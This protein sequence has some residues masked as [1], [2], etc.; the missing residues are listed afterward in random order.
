MNNFDLFEFIR[1]LRDIQKVLSLSEYLITVQT[2]FRYT[3]GRGKFIINK[4][5]Y[6]PIIETN[7]TS[8]I[9][10]ES[11]SSQPQSL[12]SCYILTND[13]ETCNKADT[14]S[15][16]IQNFLSVPA[17]GVLMRLSPVIS[18]I[19]EYSFYAFHK[20]TYDKG[21]AYFSTLCLEWTNNKWV[22]PFL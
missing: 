8:L 12:S 22:P 21:F 1:Y 11:N 7:E 14:I 15:G 6:E 2:G 16:A 9:E 17:I 4:L 19:D 5:S 3:Y 18:L 10:P 20:A 13:T